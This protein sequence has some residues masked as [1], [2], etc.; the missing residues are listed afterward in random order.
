MD[1]TIV[2]ERLINFNRYFNANLINA[3]KITKSLVLNA[4]LNKEK[5][6]LN[7]LSSKTRQIEI[8]NANVIKSIQIYRFFVFFLEYTGNDNIIAVI[9]DKN[10]NIIETRQLKFSK[11]HNFFVKYQ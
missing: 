4:F 11:M 3:V 5:N 8:L 1:T 9:K 6:K 7:I 10:G 2:L